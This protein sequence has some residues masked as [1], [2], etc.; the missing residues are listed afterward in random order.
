MMSRSETEVLQAPRTAARFAQSFP[1]R[2][3]RL[4]ARPDACSRRN[5]HLSARRLDYAR[6]MSMHGR[7]GLQTALGAGRFTAE[8]R[9]YRDCRAQGP[10]GGLEAA[11]GDV[12]VVLAIDVLDMQAHAAIAREGMEELLE[13]FGIHLADLV[14]AEVHLPDKIGALAEVDGGAGQRLVHR[15]IGMAEARDA[16]KI[17]EG[18]CDGLADDDAGVL[19]RVVEVDMGITLAAYFQV[20]QRVARQA[21]QHVIEKADSRLNVGLAGAIEVNRNRDI[22]FLCAAGDVCGA[23]LGHGRPYKLPEAQQLA[24]LC[25]RIPKHL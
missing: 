24:H 4:R 18:F 8:A 6:N 12:V 19:D 20:D 9:V 22:G 17:A 16:G 23:G 1:T 15:D 2:R 14:T 13:E 21:V 10:G 25:S 7:H 3:R 11:F 5:K